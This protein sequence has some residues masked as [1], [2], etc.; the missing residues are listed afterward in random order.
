MEQKSLRI[1]NENK[2]FFSQLTTTLT[3]ILTP[4]KLSINNIMISIKRNSMIKAYNAHLLMT[5]I[6]DTE[7]KESL[8]KKYEDTYAL[9]LE[10]VDKYIIDSVYKKVKNNM[11]TNFER[12][13]LAQYYTV[14]ALK[15]KQYIEYKHK[16][17][18]YLIKVD[19]DSVQESNKLAFLQKFNEFYVSKMDSLYKG[20]LRN[21]SIQLSDK[22]SVKLEG[23]DNIYDKIFSCLEV[24]TTDI[25]PVKIDQ[26]ANDPVLREQEEYKN[27]IAEYDRY[28]SVIIGK[29]DRRDEVK[30]QMILLGISRILFTHSLPLVAAE[31]C[32]AKLIQDVRAMIA[33]ERAGVKRDRLFILIVDLIEEYNVKLLS[34]KV[35]WDRPEERESYKEFWDKYKNLKTAELDETTYEKERLILFLKYDL[36]ELN[37]SLSKNAKLIKLYKTKLVGLGAMREIPNKCITKSNRYVKT[38]C[39]KEAE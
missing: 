1:L 29:L 39:A 31:E 37:K 26:L 12:E 18:E 14:V 13:A 30:R 27:I 7:K 9:Y 21:Y 22:K 38:V 19:Y 23:L 4:T 11:A 15:D 33:A 16:K 3:K 36:H 35:Y 2:T 8:Y 17:Q 6:D 28:E 34:T 25:L 5:D 24:Y 10:A 32:Y 20:L